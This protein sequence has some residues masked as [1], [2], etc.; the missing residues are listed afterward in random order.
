MHRAILSLLILLAA[1]PLPAATYYV[2]P[3]GG[4]NLSG[5]DRSNC[6]TQAEAEDNDASPGDIF[7]Y[8]PGDYAAMAPLSLGSSG[9]P[10]TY[11]ADPGTC[12]GMTAGWY[13]G[14]IE[15]VTGS[16]HAVTPKITFQSLGGDTPTSQYLVVEGFAV[17]CTGSYGLQ[18]GA[19]DLSAGSVADV[20]VKNCMCW[21]YVPA[22]DPWFY[23]N[24][25][26][27]HCI[28][29]Y[30][31]DA[32]RYKNLLFENVYGQFFSKGA[33]CLG[34]VHANVL[35]KN[36]HFR[37]IYRWC[38][39]FSA[40]PSSGT[41][42]D[43]ILDGL[44]LEKTITVC[45]SQIALTDSVSQQGSPTNAQ[46]YYVGSYPSGGNKY[47]TIEHDAQS[48]MRPI[49]AFEDMGSSTW[50]VTVSTVFPWAIDVDDV[51]KFH[52]DTHTVAIGIH[53]PI[54]VRNCRIHNTG[55]TGM[56]YSYGTSTTDIKIE[57]NLLYA[58]GNQSNYSIDF[59]GY[60]VG[61]NLI[62]R[63]NTI[64]SRR[65]QNYPANVRYRYG[66]A[67]AASGRAGTNLRDTWSVTNNLVVGNF[68]IP[69]GRIYN[70][71]MW[72][73]WSSCIMDDVND[74]TVYCDYTTPWDGTIFES[75]ATTPYFVCG[76]DFDTTLVSGGA[77]NQ[78][79]AFKLVAGSPAID[80]GSAVSGD[81]TS[82]DF[83][84]QSRD[85]TPDLGFDELDLGE[86]TTYL[87][88][89]GGP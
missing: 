60:P 10:I 1:A 5:S 18:G 53:R 83:E 80:A 68:Y 16:T 67:L 35:I 27:Q 6:M 63:N 13:E 66:L 24:E 78:N 11:K 45:A 12:G 74:C 77:V 29:M 54:T 88:L 62:I 64:A 73:N 7:L 69:G 14:S 15:K 50:R 20:T 23:D 32:G 17:I 71:T 84:A 81:Y 39:W 89:R 42:D 48:T 75:T 70:N 46:F 82:T 38:V 52:D 40:V 22:T 86:S 30:N 8:Q 21:G 4:G 31:S 28:S 59:S 41:W 19:I 36:C 72:C 61:D 25:P 2:S 49:S 44:H 57:N 26:T 79:A 87:L 37:D 43:F 3:S 34:Q 9:S 33:L 85:A 56:I 65:H 76:P 58:P 55:G 51:C 47:V